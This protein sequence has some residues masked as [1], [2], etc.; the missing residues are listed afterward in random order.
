MKKY[1]FIILSILI[2]FQM[3][4]QKESPDVRTG[5]KFYNSE[6]YIEAEVEYRKGLQKNPA[7]FEA[8]YNLGNSLFRQNK[9]KEALE[10]YKMA[11][12]LQTEDKAKI[13]A[14]FHNTGNSLLAEKKI[15]ESIEAYK[16]ALK[17]NPKD[18]D[19]RFNLAFAQALL[20]K[21][22]NDKDK[23]KDKDKDKDKEKDQQNKDQQNKDQQQ[24]QQQQPQMTKQ[25]AQQIL[26]ALMQ[27]EKDALDKAKQQQVRGK[28]SADKDW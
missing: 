20:K 9:Y 7:S 19:T 2:S 11:A 23:N 24:P 21:Q 16:L 12:A 3:F 10:Q 17:A 22:K 1:N 18:N 14:S 15:E 5:N 28:K 26:D 27:D 4:A 25:N 6:K 13:A 8:N